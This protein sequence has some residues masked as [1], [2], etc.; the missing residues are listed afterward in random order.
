MIVLHVFLLADRLNRT[1]A[2]G[3]R[4]ALYV[5]EAFV[6]DMDD[7][8]RE[9]GVGDLTVPKKVKK[10]A[11]GLME[12]ATA[13]RAALGGDDDAGLARLLTSNLPSLQVPCAARIAGYI[14]RQ[15]AHLQRLDFDRLMSTDAPF[16]IAALEPAP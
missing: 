13:Y 5:S 14:R 3:A 1:S 6:G 4:L 8:M 10:A 15:H 11:A 16:D 2:E 12:R 9:M 7:S